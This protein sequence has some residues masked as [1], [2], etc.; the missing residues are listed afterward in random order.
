VRAVRYVDTYSRAYGTLSIYTYN[1]VYIHIER[2]AVVYTNIYI[3]YIMCVYRTVDFGFS[4]YSARILK[5]IR[6]TAAQFSPPRIYYYNCIHTRIYIES[7]RA[8]HAPTNVYFSSDHG[9]SQLLFR[10]HIIIIPW[11]CTL[12]I[13][14]ERFFII[15]YDRFNRKV[16]THYY[17]HVYYLYVFLPI[18]IIWVRARR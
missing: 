11:L 13:H 2:Q 4:L 10:I 17:Y 9:N 16:F 7:F 12:G 14:F 5:S 8:K 6:R 15:S 3:H 18:D 1:N